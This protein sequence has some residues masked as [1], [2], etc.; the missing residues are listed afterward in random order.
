[1]PLL[2]ATILG[3]NPEIEKYNY[4]QTITTNVE[5]ISYSEKDIDLKDTFL[6]FN[7]NFNSNLELLKKQLDLFLT[8]SDDDLII[9][10]KVYNSSYFIIDNLYPS[11][12][13]EI[14]INEIYTSNY[15]TVIMDWEKE[16]GDVFSLEIGSEKLGYFIEVGS[17]DVK[18]VEEIDINNSLKD[19]LNDLSNFLNS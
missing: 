10:S 14:N 12:Y 16:N 11:I 19:L 17:V 5:C 8:S 13:N 15:G 2:T 3:L 4:L 7:R 9:S 18:Q 6:L 1:M